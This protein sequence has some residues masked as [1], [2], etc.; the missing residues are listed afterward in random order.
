MREFG[1]VANEF[2]AQALLSSAPRFTASQARSSLIDHGIAAP[3]LASALKVS[4]AWLLG[5]RDVSNDSSVSKRK[6][7]DVS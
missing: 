4:V 1:L 2:A 5:R 7:E 6:Y 3:A